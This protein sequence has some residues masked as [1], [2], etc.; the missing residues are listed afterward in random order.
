MSVVMKLISQI[1][2]IKKLKIPIYVEQGNFFLAVLLNIFRR[3]S[4][5]ASVQKLFIMPLI[6]FRYVRLNISDI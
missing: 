6:I 1:L 4:G 2:R 3:F 5:V